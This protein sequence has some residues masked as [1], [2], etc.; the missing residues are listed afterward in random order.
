MTLYLKRAAAAGVLCLGLAAAVSAGAQDHAPGPGGG[1]R[2]GHQKMFEQF[3]QKREQRLHDL[4]QIRPDQEGAFK[5]FLAASEQAMPAPGER[6][7]GRGRDCL[8]DRKMLTTPERL[9]RMGQ[10][11]AE[12]QQRFQKVAAATKTFYA[13]L[14]PEQRKAFDAMAPMMGRGRAGPMGGHGFGPRQ[15]FDGPPAPPP[16]R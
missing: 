16:P 10:R 6:E 3:R 7:R 15:G 13:A 9:D 8:P 11:M 14:S 5:T 1:E 4:L 2:A 12:R